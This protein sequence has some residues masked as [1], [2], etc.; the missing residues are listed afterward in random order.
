MARR[1]AASRGRLTPQCYLR[2]QWQSWRLPNDGP[3]SSR[4]TEFASAHGY[5]D[6]LLRQRDMRVACTCVTLEASTKNDAMTE[7]IRMAASRSG[8]AAL[9]VAV[10]SPLSTRRA[11]GKLTPPRARGPTT[12]RRRFPQRRDRARLF[13]SPK[14]VKTHLQ[15]IY[16]KLSVNSR[17]EAATKG[18]GGWATELAPAGRRF[19]ASSSCSRISSA[20][21]AL[22]PSRY[23]SVAPARIASNAATTD[24]SN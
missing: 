17:T 4:A 24:V 1:R 2:Q 23:S 22:L 18:Q 7:V 20:K 15:N 10:G 19:L 3:R 12:R 9:A 14:T 21:S 8:D 11:P 5:G 16:E 6:W 13:I